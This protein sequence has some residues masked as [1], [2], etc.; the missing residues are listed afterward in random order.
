MDESMGSGQV[1]GLGHVT[2]HLPAS[3]AS[4]NRE[5]PVSLFTPGASPLSP[6]EGE[7]ER[8]SPPF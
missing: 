3:I 8:L 7:N 2:S 1:C 4:L 6:L 5:N